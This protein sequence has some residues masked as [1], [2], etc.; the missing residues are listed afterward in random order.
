M[1]IWRSGLSLSSCGVELTDYEGGEIWDE[2]EKLCHKITCPI[3]EDHCVA[4]HQAE[5][6]RIA[7]HKGKHVYD[8]ANLEHHADEW[9]CTRKRLHSV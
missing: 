9:D 3:C 7:L 2:M 5:R 8:M 6:D 4:F 1:R